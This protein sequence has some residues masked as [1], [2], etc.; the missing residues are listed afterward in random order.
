[1]AQQDILN[2]P[3]VTP[4]QVAAAVA[5]ATI[6]EHHP[7]LEQSENRKFAIWLFLISEVMFFTVLIGAYMMARWKDPAPHEVLNVP[8]TAL[9]TFILL[10]SSYTVVRAL[11]AIQQGNRTGFLRSMVL[12]IIFGSTFVLLQ[13]YEYNNLYHEGLMLSANLYGAAFFSLTGF[14][15]AHVIIGVCWLI[16][17]FIKGFNGGFSAS[18]NWGIELMGLYWHFVDVIWILL[19]TI[20]YLI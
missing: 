1:M 6:E 10:S 17:N 2:P 20:I 15:G 3:V 11:S 8:L 16:R 14:H 5:T 12:S 19:F 13:A 4:P 9:N 18:D 7:E